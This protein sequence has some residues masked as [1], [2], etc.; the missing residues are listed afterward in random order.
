[1]PK[2]GS[3]RWGLI[4]CFGLSVIS[5]FGLFHSVSVAHAQIGAA[6][7]LE[8][9][10]GSINWLMENASAAEAT[11]DMLYNMFTWLSGMVIIW[12]IYF[13]IKL[14]RARGAESRGVRLVSDL[15]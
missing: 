13:G 6:Q 4:I 11:A 3:R 5:S 14:I 10:S 1:M 8:A 12:G 15:R 2:H 7:T 9:S